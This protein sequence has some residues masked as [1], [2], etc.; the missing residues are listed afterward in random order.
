VSQVAL[1]DAALLESGRELLATAPVT[2]LVLES[3]EGATRW[4]DVAGCEFLSRLHTLNLYDSPIGEDAAR[5]LFAS[6]HLAGLR[7]LHLGEG[8]ATP[9]MVPV[10]A[11]HLTA[12][13]EL[14]L[15]D[16]HQGELGDAG[17]AL[18][19]NHPA[20][21][22][23]TK[24][25]LLQTGVGSEGARAVAESPHL[26]RLEALSFGFQACGYG[27]NRIGPD[28]VRHVARSPQLA[29]VRNLG[30]GQNG[31]GSAGVRELVASPHLLRLN[32][33]DLGF[34]EI[35]DDG[36]A[37]LAEWPGL[38]GVKWLNLGTNDFGAAGVVALANCPHVTKLETLGLS[39]VNVG[40]A[41]LRA[42]ASSPFL[43]RL[44][45]LW[46]FARDFDA[47]AVDVLVGDNR[48]ARLA[49][50]HLAAL[51]QQFKARLKGHFGDRVTC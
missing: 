15:W 19:A 18:V 8:D 16:F 17:L 30:L 45:T 31:V 25:N 4:A 37:A 44:R 13:R 40:T 32:S 38:A 9:E 5:V 35:R 26:H 43:E 22:G 39:P 12:L 23:L 2:H 47:A 33:L 11:A 27:P 36:V 50:L 3:V 41:G 51:D 7:G 1:G 42:L 29:S 46:L 34:N 20:F 48:F 24:L 28:G 21:A 10:V 6:P 14:Y 49:D